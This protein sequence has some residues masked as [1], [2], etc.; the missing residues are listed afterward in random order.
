MTQA[1]SAGRQLAC[2]LPRRSSLSGALVFLQSFLP[3]ALIAAGVWPAQAQEVLT[4]SKAVDL[5]QK[6]SLGLQGSEAKLAQARAQVSQTYSSLYPQ[7]ALSTSVMSIKQIDGNAINLG[8]G[9]GGV[10]G[11]GGLGG[12]GGFP[13]GGAF[14]I[15]QTQL[16]L[17]QTLFD[18]FQT[19]SLLKIA[20]ASLKLG[21]IDRLGQFRK[22]GYDAATAY[23]NVLRAHK[24]HDLVV[25]A[26][27]QAKSHVQAAEQRERIGTGTRFEILQAEARLSS[28]QGQLLSATN[29][30]DLALLA[31]T[32]AVGEPLGDSILAEQTA[33]PSVE[34]GLSEDP[35]PAIDGRPEVRTLIWKR[36]IDE[37]TVDLNGK[38]NLPKAQ[39]QAQYSQQAFNSGRQFTVLA[40]V[41][42]PLIDWGKADHK[43]RQSRQ[44]LRLTDVN[45]AMARRNLAVDIQA[46]L[47][48]RQDSR[49][50][51]PIAQKGLGL[52][53]EAYRLAKVLYRAGVGTGF[54]VIDAQTGLIQAQSTLIQATFDLQGSEIRVAQALG[55]DLNT[56]GSSE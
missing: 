10:G 56:G 17:S 47:L 15:L 26:L 6:N 49:S 8:G 18:G 14:N 21:E 35:T 55:I 52:A 45:L 11:I 25:A 23:I 37:A 43:T 12:G 34:F 4:L 16:T 44:D 38:A 36:R 2:P 30:V 42:W 9:V 29:G 46:A 39:A 5:A 51:V 31:L 40:A 7:L 53:L 48:S 20:D 19:A 3:L 13:S 1:A 33:I 50:R 24:L 22:A 32:N 41:N 28:V 54:D 27:E